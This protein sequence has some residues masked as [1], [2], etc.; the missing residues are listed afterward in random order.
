MDATQYRAIEKWAKELDG[1]FTL[2]DLKVALDASSEAMLYRA[3][4]Q[5]VTRGELIKVKR[6]IYATPG[7]SLVTISSRIEPNAYLS[8]GTVLARTA[9]IG[10][11]PARRVQAVK[12][13]SPRT[14]RCELGTIEHLSI[15]SRLYF[16]FDRVE[17]E[18]VASPEKAFL[19]VCYFTY[20]GRRFSFDPATDVN[21]EGLDFDTIERYLG[22]YDARFVRFFNRTW[23]RP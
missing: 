2:A 15:S 7:A 6:G 14:Y 12:T 13:G 16:G 11:I 20:R 8:T 9:A 23:R 22:S 17:G 5:M 4:A 19:D 3:L 10:S 1:V 21:L 18:L